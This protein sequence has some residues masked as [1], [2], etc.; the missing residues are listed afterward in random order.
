MV[1][2]HSSDHHHM[3]YAVDTSHEQAICIRNPFLIWHL[4]EAMALF[5]SS[6]FSNCISFSFFLNSFFSL[7]HAECQLNYFHFAI[8]LAANGCYFAIRL[9][10]VVHTTNIIRLMNVTLCG[11]SAIQYSFIHRS[12]CA[13]VENIIRNVQTSSTGSRISN[14]LK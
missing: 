11:S 12:E 13:F 1:A 8:W 4:S 5:A 3:W 10:F 14:M 6:F 7:S 2:C 9:F